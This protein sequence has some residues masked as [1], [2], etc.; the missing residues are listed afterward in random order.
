MKQLERCSYPFG[1][2]TSLQRF[3]YVG[4]NVLIENL[5]IYGGQPIDAVFKTPQTMAISLDKALQDKVKN[6]QKST[7]GRSIA[8]C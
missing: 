2:T 7:R 6:G 3:D 4:W 1:I 8:G 5:T